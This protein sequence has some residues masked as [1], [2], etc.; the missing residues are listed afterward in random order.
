[1]P[2][3]SLTIALEAGFSTVADLSYRPVQ[4][5]LKEEFDNRHESSLPIIRAGHENN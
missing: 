5:A 3:A 1:M 4:D 2:F